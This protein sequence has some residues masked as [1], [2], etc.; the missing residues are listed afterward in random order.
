MTSE[1][2][3]LNGQSHVYKECTLLILT[4]SPSPYKCVH[5]TIFD[6]H[7]FY[8][9]NK[10]SHDIRAFKGHC[11]MSTLCQYPLPFTLLVCTQYNVDEHSFFND[12][13]VSCDVRAF[14]PYGG[15]VTRLQGVHFVNTS[16]PSPYK[17]VHNTMLTFEALSTNVMCIYLFVRLKALS[18]C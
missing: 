2:S 17:Y 4:P 15:I 13:K 18:A 1:R 8:G 9:E 14:S 6:K 7:S 11:H 12:S 10:V 3:H 16:S 5:N